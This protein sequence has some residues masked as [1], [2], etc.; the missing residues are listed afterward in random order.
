MAGAEPHDHADDH[1]H[2][3]HAHEGHGHDH[4]PRARDAHARAHGHGHDHAHGHD[5]DHAHGLAELRRTPLRRLAIAFGITASFMLIEVIV[6]LWSGSLALLADAGHMVADAA[7]LGLAMIAQRVS[8]QQRTR[9][10]TYGHRR[11]EVLAAFANGVALALTA[12]WIFS[13][14][15]QRFREPRVIDGTAMTVTAASSS[16]SSP[17]GCSPSARTATT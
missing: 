17:P 2:K 11:A 1:D 9:A 5:E 10:R 14:A 8:T 16:T 7:A 13:E 6:G 4:A 3:G 15:A 12:I